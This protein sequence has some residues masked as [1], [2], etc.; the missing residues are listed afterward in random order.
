MYKK[1]S[2]TSGVISVS[3]GTQLS[4]IIAALYL[5]G[6]SSHAGLTIVCP[7]TGAGI[8]VVGVT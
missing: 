4:D 7:S 5:N 3:S 2:S 1:T 8:G 6:S